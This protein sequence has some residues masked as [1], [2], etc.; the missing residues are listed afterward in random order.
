MHYR[1]LLFLLCV[2]SA[3]QAQDLHFST[4]FTPPVSNFFQRV[5]KEADN[6][7][8]NVTITLEVLPAERSLTL[9]ER[10]INDGEC[11]RITDVVFRS[12]QNMVAVPVSFYSIRYSVFTKKH[13]VPIR[14]F[15]DLKPWSVGTVK[16]WKAAV[17][18]LQQLQ[19]ANLYIVTRP[20]QLFQMLQQER[21]DFGVMGYMSGRKTIADLKLQ[22]IRPISPPLMEKKLYLLLAKKH[23]SLVTEFTRVFNDMMNDGTIEALY[24]EIT[25]TM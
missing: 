16:G 23:Q 10:G 24:K 18:N 17:D 5:L 22:D 13:D 11:C 9:V 25:D 2:T 8:E 6:R 21:I 15:S 19:P 14:T 20:Q 7:L 4:G 12:Y 1:L 3:V